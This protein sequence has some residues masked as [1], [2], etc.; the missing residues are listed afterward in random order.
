MKKN[1]MRMFMLSLLGVTMCVSGCNNGLTDEPDKV[2]F[3]TKPINV[4]M[5]FSAGGGGDLQ[6]RALEK[7][8]PK[9]LGQSFIVTNKTG[10]GGT[11]GWNELAISSADGYTIGISATEVLLQPL[12]GE[13]K[14][15][16]PTALEPLAQMST[17]PCLIVVKADAPWEN[18]TELINYCKENP[19][20]V[21]FGHGGIG[22]TSHLV[23][24]IFAQKAEID[25]EQV[26]FRGGAESTAALLGNHVQFVVANPGAL[27]EQIRGGT[28]RA[29]AVSSKER[30]MRP[31]L[32]QVPTFEEL[33][34]DIILEN[35]Y[36]VVAP[37]EISPEVKEKLVKSIK[38]MILDS[39]FKE[40]VEQ[41]G[42]QVEYLDADQSKKKWIKDSENLKKILDDT[43]VLEQIQAQKK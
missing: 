28:I 19:R 39:S 7:L 26:P 12:Y 6:A 24:Q 40:N 32:E 27:I 33:G 20:K 17:A 38:A 18:L 23:G 11:V 34:Y 13:T 21:K 14:Y 2:D 1:I 10:G 5:P 43:G 30:L 42:F 9:Y 8:A 3:P 15:H 41:L 36:G 22:A 25:I 31:E 4:I 16:Y 29:L 35:W 37:K